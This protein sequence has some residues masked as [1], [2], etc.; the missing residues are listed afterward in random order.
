MKI[1]EGTPEQ[2]SHH[3]RMMEL[4]MQD[5]EHELKSYCVECDKTFYDE[6]FKCASCC[7]KTHYKCNVCGEIIWD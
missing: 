7:S 2:Y 4:D 3:A 6:T 5:C 1:E